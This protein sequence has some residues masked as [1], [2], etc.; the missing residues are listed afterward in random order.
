[1]LVVVR[2]GKAL[3]A[4]AGERL[5]RWKLPNRVHVGESLP[6]G[7]TGKNDRRSLAD[8]FLRGGL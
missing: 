7:R 8:L 1:M 5:E 2:A 6:L 3:H 4:W